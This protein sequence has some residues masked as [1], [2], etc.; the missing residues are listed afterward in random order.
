MCLSGALLN[1]NGVELGIF[2]PRTDPS[3]SAVPHLDGQWSNGPESQEGLCELSKTCLFLTPTFS[4][5]ILLISLLSISRICL[6]PFISVSSEFQTWD[7]MIIDHLI[8]A[9][10]LSSYLDHST[11]KMFL[12]FPTAHRI[13][14]RL[15]SMKQRPSLTGSCPSLWSSPAILP[16]PFSAFVAACHSTQSHTVSCFRGFA[17]A[18][19]PKTPLMSFFANSYTT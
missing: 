9:I 11:L 18:V 19:L 10:S 15:T 6:S 12:G 14:R 5:H 8:L 16:P 2:L 17:A 3:P 4:V 13:K 1:G 7:Q